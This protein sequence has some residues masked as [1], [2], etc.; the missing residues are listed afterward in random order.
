MNQ[1]LIFLQNNVM[2]IFILKGVHFKLNK[3]ER[4]PS[5]ISLLYRHKNSPFP[6][7]LS[8]S[9][10]VWPRS[11]LPKSPTFYFPFIFPY[12]SFLL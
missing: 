2:N 4:Q 9:V 10:P 3:L 11:S 6:S 8:P 7:A 12:P 1:N 5:K